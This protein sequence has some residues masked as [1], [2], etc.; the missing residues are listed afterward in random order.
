VNGLTRSPYATLL[1]IKQYMTATGKDYITYDG[2]KF[3][4]SR[5][6]LYESYQL[7]DRTLDRALRKLSEAGFFNRVYIK[8]NGKKIV[9]F[10]PTSA[11]YEFATETR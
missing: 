1:I 7:T 8:R 9:L 10:K 6:R 11:F 5:N 2:L 3:F 4:C